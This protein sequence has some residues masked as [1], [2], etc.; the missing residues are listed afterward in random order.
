MKSSF[1]STGAAIH[2]VGSALD[3]TF[4][5][6]QKAAEFPR[7][8]IVDDEV[9]VVVEEVRIVVEKIRMAVQKVVQEVRIAAEKMEEDVV[10]VMIGGTAG[11]YWRET[12]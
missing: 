7:K 8:R 12:W 1:T 5:F 11:N 2:R 6:G 10:M 4:Q 9:R 3:C